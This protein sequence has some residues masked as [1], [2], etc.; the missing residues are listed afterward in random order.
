MHCKLL[1]FWRPA[2]A[3]EPEASGRSRRGFSEGVTAALFLTSTKHL[4]LPAAKAAC[5][6]SPGRAVSVP[7]ALTEVLFPNCNWLCNTE[8]CNNLPG[9]EPCR[10]HAV[11]QSSYEIC[12][13]H[14]SADPLTSSVAARAQASSPLI[15]PCS[16]ACTPYIHRYGPKWLGRLCPAPLLLR[17]PIHPAPGEEGTSLC[18]H[19]DKAHLLSWNDCQERKSKIVQQISGLISFTAARPLEDAF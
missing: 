6:L 17:A 11:P 2:A 16:A 15:L 18:S 19:Q 5:C 4:F 13:P 8:L 12:H 9:T 3:P 1:I 10:S 7:P 14:G